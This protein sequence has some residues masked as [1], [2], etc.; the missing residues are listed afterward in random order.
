MN[1]KNVMLRKLSE[2]DSE[3]IVR[4]RNSDSV[5]FNLFDSGLIS[6]ESHLEYYRNKVLTG[7]CAQYIISV[8]EDNKNNDIGTIYIKR[9][10]HFNKKGEIGIFIGEEKFRGK[11][12]AKPAVYSILSIAF[13]E[14]ELN[15][16]YLYVYADNKP[17]INTYLSIGFT[18]EGV[19]KEDYC[20]NNEL[21]DVV[22]MGMTKHCFIQKEI[23]KNM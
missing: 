23:N 20:R 10:D 1:M 13:N 9:I 11:G 8:I 16:V 3:N 12:Y 7:Q 19:L 22:V 4:W 21:V 18:E 14:L 15:R 6:V 17:A 2:S 5:R